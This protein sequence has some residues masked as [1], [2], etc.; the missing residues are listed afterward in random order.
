MYKHDVRGTGFSKKPLENQQ[1]NEGLYFEKWF[2]KLQR[3][4]I[5]AFQENTVL[6]QTDGMT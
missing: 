5:D 4:K 2:N 6:Q 3:A 1:A